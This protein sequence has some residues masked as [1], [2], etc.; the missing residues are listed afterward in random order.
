[1]RL[2]GD[3]A[4]Y[5]RI[6]LP[7]D[8]RGRLGRRLP[9]QLLPHGRRARAG[10]AYRTGC[11]PGRGRT[12]TRRTAMPGPR[13]DF[14]A[15]MAAWF[16]HWLRGTRR[17]TRTAA[18][19]SSARRPG[20]SST[21]TCTRAGG[22]RCRPCR[23]STEATLDLT[24][25]VSLDVVAGRRHRG[26]DR[27]RRPPAVG[28]VRRPA[29]RRRALADLGDRA[30]AGRRSSATR[31]CGAGSGPTE[32]AGVAVGQ[33]LRRLPRRHLRAGHPRQPRPRLPRRGPCTGRAVTARARQEYD[34]VVDLDAC[35]YAFAPASG[36]GCRSP[37]PTGRTP[38]LPPRRSR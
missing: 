20:R 11:W 6:E 36:C 10:T 28:A 15:E 25:P 9:Q 31:C 1:M 16:D 24:A 12:P 5:E 22:S 34:V 38:S 17:R 27:L 26:L 8:D 18:T 2:G 32:P 14:D 19:C 13:I 30:A 35:A 4:G 29:A 37:A 23:R 21:S 7:G 3:D 33:A